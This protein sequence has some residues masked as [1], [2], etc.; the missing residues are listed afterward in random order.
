MLL[1]MGARLLLERVWLLQEVLYLAPGCSSHSSS[2]SCNR[3]CSGS[4]QHA[5]EGGPSEF[6]QRA[7]QNAMAAL[8][9]VAGTEHTG[10]KAHVSMKKNR[11]QGWR[12]SPL[13]LLRKLGVI[14]N[15]PRSQMVQLAYGVTR[16][17]HCYLSL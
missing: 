3:F 1:S 17:H 12:R 2:C 14:L 16:D 9:T 8:T 10:R 4:T 7:T 5:W 11:W 6:Y 15:I 13:W